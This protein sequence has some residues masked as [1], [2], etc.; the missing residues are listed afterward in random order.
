MIPHSLIVNCDQ[1]SAEWF[2]ARR[3]VV[4]SSNLARIMAKGKGRQTYMRE[5]IAETLIDQP[6]GEGYESKAMRHGKEF[7]PLAQQRYLLDAPLGS[8]IRSVG[9]V[10]HDE[11][12]RSGASGD[13]V[14]IGGESVGVLEIKCPQPSTHIGYKIDGVVPKEYR[15]QVVGELLIPGVEWVDFSSYC[16]SLEASGAGWFSVRT[17]VQQAEKDM[18]AAKQEIASF[19][20]DLDGALRILQG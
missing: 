16:P 12:Q 18:R 13:G 2:E 14:V 6:E 7:E 1:G 15:W 4:T 5:L 9:F 8:D 20:A 17:T 10:Y 11:T 3:G 19:L